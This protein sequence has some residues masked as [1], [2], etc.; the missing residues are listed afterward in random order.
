MGYTMA[1]LKCIECGRIRRKSQRYRNYEPGTI[2]YAACGC[3][4]Y[5]GLKYVPFE[6]I[7]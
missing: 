2:L 5:G 3:Q 4:R 7:S 6:V 1:K